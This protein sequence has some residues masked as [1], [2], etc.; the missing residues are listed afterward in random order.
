MGFQLKQSMVPE[1]FQL[2]PM[3]WNKTLRKISGGSRIACMFLFAEYVSESGAEQ[4]KIIHVQEREKVRGQV[5]EETMGS[6]P[7]G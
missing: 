5:S 3:G 2:W 4:N 7:A 1:P 6:A